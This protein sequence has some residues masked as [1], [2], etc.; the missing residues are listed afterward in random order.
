MEAQVPQPAAKPNKV[1]EQR[2]ASHDFRRRESTPVH[3]SRQLR[4][5]LD[6]GPQ[7]VPEASNRY[8]MGPFQQL[9]KG[10]SYRLSELIRFERESS[11]V[12]QQN[13]QDIQFSTF[14]N[15]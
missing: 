15:P 4:S 5:A 14:V 10:I 8:L 13:K 1:S 3:G 6:K 11:H 9:S 2:R 12:I 7:D